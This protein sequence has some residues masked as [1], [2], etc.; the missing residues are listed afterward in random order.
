MGGTVGRIPSSP[1]RRIRRLKYGQ[2]EIGQN[3][4]VMNLGF[5][6]LL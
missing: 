5:G 4:I 6:F 2:A 3:R 1:H